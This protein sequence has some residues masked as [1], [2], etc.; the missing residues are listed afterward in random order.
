MSDNDE[1]TIIIERDNPDWRKKASCANLDPA[2]FII[3]RGQDVQP[4]LNV[5]KTC[6]VKDPCLR[7]AIDN[8]EIGIWG[9]TTGKQRRKMKSLTLQNTEALVV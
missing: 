5:C 3:E 2:M 7:Y 1:R 9:G 6:P 4:A 8:N